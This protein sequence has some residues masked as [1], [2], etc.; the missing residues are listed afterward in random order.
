MKVRNRSTGTVIYKVP[1]FN[2]RREFAPG[3]I[4]EIPYKAMGGYTYIDYT[5]FSH[6]SLL[7]CLEK[8]CSL[9]YNIY[10]TTSRI[11]QDR[12]FSPDVISPPFTYKI[13]TENSLS[14]E[15]FK[16]NTIIFNKITTTACHWMIFKISIEK[17]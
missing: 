10:S 12:I 14:R 6:D 5:L 11:Q 15:I 4:K 16:M 1:D 13:F 17:S 8:Y 7:L 9:Y 3:E 2:V